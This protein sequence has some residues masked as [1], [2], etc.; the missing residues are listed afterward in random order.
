MLTRL[1]E[2]GLFLI[3]VS[4]VI[5]LVSPL[6][7][8]AQEI[9]PQNV[10]FLVDA[11]GDGLSYLPAITG[12]LQRFVTGARPGDSFACYQFSNKPL[13]VAKAKINH[14][15]DIADLQ[16]QLLQLHEAEKSTNYSPAIERGLSDLLQLFQQH[17]SHEGLLVLITDGR[18]EEDSW[19]ER[20]TFNELL[21]K[22]PQLQTNPRFSFVC[23]FIGRSVES[24]LQDYLL[25]A[26]ARLEYWPSDAKWL[27]KVTLSDI[28]IAEKEKSLGGMPEAPFFGTFTLSFFPRRPPDRLAM[29]ELDLEENLTDK[30]LDKLFDVRPRR[31]ICKQQPWTEMFT[32]ETRGLRRGEY[33][34][35]FL[36]YPSEPKSMFVSPTSIPFHF[37]IS[38]VLRIIVPEP[39]RFGPTGLKG[40]YEESKKIYIQAERGDP[41]NSLNAIDVDA[42]ILLPEG[43]QAQVRPVL[44]EGMIEVQVA[45]SLNEEVA[46]SVQ[47]QYEGK[48]K[49]SSPS[50]WMF[51]QNELPF[52]VNVKK[53]PINFRRLALYAGI[54]AGALV[55]IG[56]VLLLFFRRIRT[57]LADYLAKRTK[58]TGKLVPVKDPTRGLAKKV[59]FY[60]LAERKRKKEIVIGVGE[61]ADFEISHISLVDR[62]FH[63]SGLRQK[64]GVHTFIEGRNRAQVLINGVPRVGKAPLKHL[65]QVQLGAFEFRYEGPLPL[66]QV[67]LYYLSGQVVQGW[68]L[69]WDMTK[70]GFHFIKRNGGPQ[71][72]EEYVRF[73]ELKAIAFVRDFDGEITKNLLSL[74]TPRNGHHVFLIF[75]DGEEMSGY[76]LEWEPNGNKFYFFPHARGLNILFLLVEQNAVAE[77]KLLKENEKAAKRSQK[78]FEKILQ[79]LADNLKANVRI[80]GVKGVV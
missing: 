63:I 61:G 5:C 68:L 74:K 22:F 17:P 9:P 53:K 12:I 15:N 50:G 67:V 40:K 75:A 27:E 29:V 66:Q 21:R 19:S 10:V 58:P 44:R 37:S 18:G 80:G 33:R 79:K 55:A 3:V 7:A 32:L 36:F 16:E 4:L 77:L 51:S 34:G 54:A 28:C 57:G 2:S 76:V 60:S 25:S 14:K 71:P 6:P 30:S 59:N 47:G 46:D 42:D 20:F 48:I 56:L 35:R 13:L 45:V 39:L 23:F 31:I 65:D 11:S 49:F 52:S 73:Y 62:T 70:E 78:K 69:E 26:G 24:D 41:P 1:S 64:D 8:L 43:L 72:G 38:S